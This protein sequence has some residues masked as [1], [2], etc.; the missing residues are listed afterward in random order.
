MSGPTRLAVVALSATLSTACFGTP[1][2]LAPGLGGSVGVPHHGVLTEADELPRSGA[3]YT[4]FRPRGAAYFGVSRLVRAIERAAATVERER[5]GGAP[6][7]VGDLSGPFG[8]KIPRHNSHRSGRDVDFL[9]YVTN[10]A[11][12]PMRN[13]GF[14]PLGADGL[15]KLEDGRYIRLDVER[16]WLL[17]KALLTDPDIDIQFLFISRD[18][19]ALV[20]DYALARET[21]LELVWHAQTVMLQP[22]DSLPHSD[23]VHVR[24]ACRPEDML[25]GCQGGGP[26]WDWFD[27]VPTLG[28]EDER[29]LA[30]I[31][32]EDPFELEPLGP[33]GP[34]VEAV[35]Q[36]EAPSL[37]AGQT[38]E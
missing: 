10:P 8:G 13:L 9:F 31:A 36:G 15:A 28:T 25:R 33:V 2:P 38:G 22:G 26:Y 35:A 4:R 7:V 34:P 14:I 16:Q 11:G 5:P 17:F 30:Q 24:V 32:S 37:P 3:G 29:L 19:E 12:A 21:D 6:L 1:T 27:P 18:L 20:I 23:H